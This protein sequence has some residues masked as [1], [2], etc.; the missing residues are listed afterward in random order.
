MRADERIAGGLLLNLV[1]DFF[2]L[3]CSCFVGFL[4]VFADFYFLITL[5]KFKKYLAV[6]LGQFFLIFLVKKYKETDSEKMDQKIRK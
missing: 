6:L 5:G 4:R 2:P 3:S 1:K